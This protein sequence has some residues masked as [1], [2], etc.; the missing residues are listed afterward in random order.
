MQLPQHGSADS[1]RVVAQFADVQTAGGLSF[2]GVRFLFD[3]RAQRS[4]QGLAFLADAAADQQ[5]FRLE[6]VDV[7]GQGSPARMPS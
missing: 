7:V 1:A 6:D 4:K 3:V 2:D 5:D